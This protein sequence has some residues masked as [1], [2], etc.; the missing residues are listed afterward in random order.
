MLILLAACLGANGTE[1]T[2]APTRWNLNLTPYYWGRV[3]MPLYYRA[4]LYRKWLYFEVGPEVLW[5]EQTRWEPEPA[6]RFAVSGIFWG[7]TGR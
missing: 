5:R 6:I 1:R 2:E 3:W 7:T 4:P